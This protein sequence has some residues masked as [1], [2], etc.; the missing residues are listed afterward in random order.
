MSH[1]RGQDAG[2]SSAVSLHRLPARTSGNPRLSR[3]TPAR[4]QAGEQQRA[5]V[6]GVGGT[7][8]AVVE[9]LATRVR[10][11]D[12]PHPAPPGVRREPKERVLPAATVGLEG[13]PGCYDV[14]VRP[15]RPVCDERLI[16]IEELGWC[17]EEGV[18]LQLGVGEK[19]SRSWLVIA[20][21]RMLVEDGRLPPFRWRPKSSHHP[22]HPDPEIE[23]AHAGQQTPVVDLPEL[24]DVRAAAI[25]VAA[26]TITGPMDLP[27][28]LPSW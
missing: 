25:P 19:Q 2:S 24:D 5:A 28:C 12:P 20:A 18:E 14:V 10:V 4:Q 21:Q 7:L 6:P 23:G 9:Q 8:R 1:L 11:G 22:V 13:V 15:M 27:M 16:A 26:K 17:R 3:S